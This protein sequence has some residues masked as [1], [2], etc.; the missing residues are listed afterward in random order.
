MVTNSN[1]S[2]YNNFHTPLTP[3]ATRLGEPKCLISDQNLKGSN[4]ALADIKQ[5]IA[6]NF[7]LSGDICKRVPLSGAAEQRSSAAAQRG[8]RGVNEMIYF[9]NIIYNF[10]YSFLIK[11]I[12][13]SPCL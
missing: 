12:I 7:K 1:I 8:V 5:T 10:L 4:F 3:C 6:L 13:Q 9:I 2:G 11:I